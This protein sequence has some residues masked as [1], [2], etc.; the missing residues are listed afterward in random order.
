MTISMAV[1]ETSSASRLRY[2]R[3]VSWRSRV[4]E[5]SKIDEVTWWQD[6]YALT[7]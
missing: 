5:V 6:G 2:L 1:V 7:S 3:K 4:I